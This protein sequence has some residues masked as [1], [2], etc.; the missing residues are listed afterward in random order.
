M[1]RKGQE[2]GKW[3]EGWTFLQCLV[4]TPIVSLAWAE[5]TWT[6]A[7]RYNRM[8]WLTLQTSAVTWPDL[9]HLELV[10]AKTTLNYLIRLSSS[11]NINNVSVSESNNWSYKSDYQWA[12]A[13]FFF[14]ILPFIRSFQLQNPLST[15]I[16]VHNRCWKYHIKRSLFDFNKIR[17]SAVERHLRKRPTTD[18]LE[19]ANAWLY[20][21]IYHAVSL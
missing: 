12:Y 17:S 8:H 10:N 2:R 6:C 15:T 20:V 18:K 13:P 11:M 14:G 3:E 1:G 16:Y 19:L 4:P 7:G 9:Y 5:R 21:R